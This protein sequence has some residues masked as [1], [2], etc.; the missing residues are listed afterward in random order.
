MTTPN[1]IK[2]AASA[3]G[4]DGGRCTVD[5]G[6]GPN[7]RVRT[8]RNE[9]GTVVGTHFLH[10]DWYHV[11]IDNS[12]DTLIPPRWN[13]DLIETYMECELTILP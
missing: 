12:G 10:R 13:G 7:V 5:A 4:L 8:C 2:P 3:E 6:L 11:R 9:T 1:E